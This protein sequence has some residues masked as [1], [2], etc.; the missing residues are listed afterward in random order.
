MIEDK[1]KS[2]TADD[3][4][5]KNDDSTTATTIPL[6]VQRASRRLRWTGLFCLV[7]LQPVSDVLAIMHASPA[8]LAPF[9]GLSLAWIMLFSKQ[10]TGEPPR[11][12]QIVGSALI[13]VGLVLVVAF[14]DRTNNE[15]VTL[16]D[17][18]RYILASTLTCWLDGAF[19]VL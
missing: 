18:V 15:G 3:N 5:D 19:C 6:H 7:L 14:G 13:G 9:S 10:I 2:G 11:R 12:M 4:D 1:K 16:N 17:V 8:L